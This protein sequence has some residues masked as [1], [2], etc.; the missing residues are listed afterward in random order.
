MLRYYETFVDVNVG[1]VSTPMVVVV[2]NV[3]GKV[4]V[5]F[6]LSKFLFRNLSPPDAPRASTE[7]TD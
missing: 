4:R 3:V 5:A 1:S 6:S 2:V 7:D